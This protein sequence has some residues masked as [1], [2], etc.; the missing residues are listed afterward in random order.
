M[1][2]GDA[3]T[4]LEPYRQAA[5]RHGDRFASLLWASPST[6]AARFDAIC[7][8][9]DMRGRTVLDAGCGRGDLIDFL[10][11]REIVI[12][13]YIGLE[14][15]D[16]LV[17]AAKRKKHSAMQIIQGDFVRDPALLDAEADVIVFSGS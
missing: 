6:Q 9:A 3:P 7:R 16:E 15:V 2:D 17:A 13:K 4:Y 11:Q 8:L 1:A 14:A 12:Q 5:S 10:R